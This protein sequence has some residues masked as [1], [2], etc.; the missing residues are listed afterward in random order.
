MKMRNKP[1]QTQTT[2]QA[3]R[4]KSTL[5]EEQYPTISLTTQEAGGVKKSTCNSRSTSEKSF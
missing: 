4:I 5:T 1:K 3:F 2:K